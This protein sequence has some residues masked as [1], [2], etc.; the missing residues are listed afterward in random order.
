MILIKVHSNGAVCA[1]ISPS[2]DQQNNII[3]DCFVC[4]RSAWCMQQAY[5][6]SPSSGDVGHYVLQVQVGSCICGREQFVVKTTRVDSLAVSVTH[7]H[8][9]GWR[10][11]PQFKSVMLSVW[12]KPLAFWTCFTRQSK[13]LFLSGSR[14]VFAGWGYSRSGNDRHS[15]EW[16]PLPGSWVWHDGRSGLERRYCNAARKWY[17]GRKENSFLLLCKCWCKAFDPTLIVGT[18]CLVVFYEW[19]PPALIKK[20]A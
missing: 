6:Q 9:L 4:N 5:T 10:N 1:L 15:T 3:I 2:V 20:D 17:Q 13:F 14:Y 16:W 7:N 19:K 8:H 12:M 11:M 18:W